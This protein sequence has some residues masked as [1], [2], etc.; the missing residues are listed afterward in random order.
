MISSASTLTA[1][2]ND[3]KVGVGKGYYE[4]SESGKTSDYDVHVHPNVK[5][6]KGEIIGVGLPEPSGTN[7]GTP[8]K[9]GDTDAYGTN[10]VNSSPSVVL[11]YSVTNHVTKQDGKTKTYT[12]VTRQIG[13]YNNKGQVGTPINYNKFKKVSSKI[14]NK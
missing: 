5:N 14:N 13:F 1:S 4:L 2:N 11:G 10:G 9:T 12:T 8:D 7:G 6:D 3:E